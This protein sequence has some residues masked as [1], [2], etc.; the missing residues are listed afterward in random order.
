MRIQSNNRLA[1]YQV[2]LQELQEQT[3]MLNAQLPG[4][5]SQIVSMQHYLSQNCGDRKAR[6]E[7][8]AL[9]R[10]YQHMCTSIR[11]NSVRMQTLQRQITAECARAMYGSGRRYR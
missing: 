6:G 5:Q 4:L 7:V 11:R 1:H 2:E 3:A 9:Q 8:S 10:R